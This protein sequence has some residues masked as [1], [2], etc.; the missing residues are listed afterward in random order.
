MVIAAALKVVTL[1]FMGSSPIMSC[2]S[3]T[4]NIIGNVLD[5]KSKNKGSIPFPSL[6]FLV[7]DLIPV[8]K[9]YNVRLINENQRFDSFQD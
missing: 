6:C 5:C 8:V 3:I 4:G 1:W 9:W 7:Y 2:F